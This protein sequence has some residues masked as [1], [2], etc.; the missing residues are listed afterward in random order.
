MFSQI[1][2]LHLNS[3]DYW[4]YED[5]TKLIVFLICFVFKEALC[6]T[7]WIYSPPSLLLDNL[8]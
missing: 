1:I 6:V 3:T 8:S 7:I 4:P 2:V 5:I